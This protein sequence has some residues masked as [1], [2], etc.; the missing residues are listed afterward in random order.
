MTAKELHDMIVGK[1]GK[2]HGNRVAVAR[3]ATVTQTKSGLI[4]PQ[5]AQHENQ[6]A[7]VVLVGD[8]PEVQALGLTPGDRL[9]IQKFGGVD[10]K[11]RV[12]SDHYWLEVIH[13]LDV[14]ITYP[15][16]GAPLQQ[17]GEKPNK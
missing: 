3:E 17:G 13:A 7:A 1:G 15:D 11:Q 8:G 14:Y 16:D 9:Y 6:Y 5:T 10:I 2:L 12:G 4:L